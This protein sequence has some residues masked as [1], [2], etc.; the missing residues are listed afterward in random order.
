MKTKTILAIG[1]IAGAAI[2]GAVTVLEVA[3]TVVAV[4]MTPLGWLTKGLHPYPS[5]SLANLIIALPLIFIY[6]GCLGALVGL[7]L[8]ATVRMFLRPRGRN[9][10]NPQ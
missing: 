2:G 3:P 10:E 1:F 6:W 9:Y 4:L 5:E 8:R 7:L